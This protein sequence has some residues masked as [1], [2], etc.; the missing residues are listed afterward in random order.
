[1]SISLIFHFLVHNPKMCGAD[2]YDLLRNNISKKMN[3]NIDYL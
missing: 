3:T 1:M 2:F